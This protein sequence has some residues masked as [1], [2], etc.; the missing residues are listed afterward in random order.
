MKIVSS[1]IQLEHEYDSV[2]IQLILKPKRAEIVSKVLPFEDKST[3][4]F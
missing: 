2:S 3:L 1:M 4:R